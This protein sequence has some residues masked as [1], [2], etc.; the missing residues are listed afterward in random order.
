MNKANI[1]KRLHK[2]IEEY[3]TEKK[4]KNFLEVLLMEENV[5]ALNHSY[6]EYYKNLVN[7]YINN[8]SE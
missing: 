4:I 7:K 1:N 2:E 5:G 6:K 8:D 3:D